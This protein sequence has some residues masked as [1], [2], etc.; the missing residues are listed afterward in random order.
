MKNQMLIVKG[1][2]NVGKSTTVKAGFELLLRSVLKKQ[3]PTNVKFLYLTGREVAAVIKIGA[4]GV[5]ISTRGDNRKEVERALAFFSKEKC[6]IVVC[7]TRSSGAP[8]VAAQKFALQNLKIT[9]A[10]LPKE[11]EG[12]TSK[13]ELANKAFAKKIHSWAT[14]ALTV[15]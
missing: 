8:Y 14:K 1:P 15:A 3:E 7:A 10:E 13:R 6:K 12:N 9:P 11:S 2:G 5:G 4:I